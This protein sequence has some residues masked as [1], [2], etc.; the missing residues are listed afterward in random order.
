LKF[1]EKG[2][3]PVINISCRK[4]NAGEFVPHSEPYKY[5]SH[6]EIIFTDNGIGFEQEYAEQI[7]MIF[8]RLHEQYTYAGSGIGLALC[9]KIVNNHHGSISAKGQKDKGSSFSII[10]PE[11]QVPGK[12]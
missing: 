11:K 4:L 2:R 9:R 7:F 1:S 3:Q 12:I 6:Y 5:I 8:Q 10:L